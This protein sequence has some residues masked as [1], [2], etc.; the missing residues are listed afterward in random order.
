MEYA[1]LK[2]LMEKYHVSEEQLIDVLETQY[3]RIMCEQYNSKNFFA[4]LQN[5]RLCVYHF[6]ESPTSAVMVQ[7]PKNNSSITRSLQS[8]V[9]KELINLQHAND[10]QFFK[11]KIDQLFELKIKKRRDSEHLLVEVCNV[12][13]R[14]VG[15][16]KLSKEQADSQMKT[17][18]P[19][20]TRVFGI[21]SRINTFTNENGTMFVRDIV[22]ENHSEKFMEAF[23][24]KMIPYIEN[25]V[26]HIEK[27]ARIPGFRTK[28]VVSSPTST[29]NAAGMCIGKGGEIVN[30]LREYLASENIDFVNEGYDL[31]T[32]LRSYCRPFKVMHIEFLDANVVKV[33]IDT[34]DLGPLVHRKNLQLLKRLLFDEKS[35]GTSVGLSFL[36]YSEYQEECIQR[37]T[38]LRNTLIESGI[39]ENDAN[40]IISQHD[41]LNDLVFNYNLNVCDETKRIL[42]EQLEHRYRIMLQKFISAGGKK[43]FFDYIRTRCSLVQFLELESVGVIS[44]DKLLEF[45][46]AS[47]LTRKCNIDNSLATLLLMEV[48][49]KHELDT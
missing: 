9:H 47:D 44:F 46:N 10:Y 40:A 30:K 13:Y 39:S 29:N 16:L 38:Q 49:N 23:L 45:E 25:G 7:A 11:D 14:Y 35:C 28:V 20:G 5:G 37:T 3:S 33:V 32:K 36:T 48:K 27:I 2:G 41:D 1:S 42:A 4:K 31:A 24:H 6:N 26:I 22:F 34:E 43:E 8:A 15:D 12:P 18:Y 17:A 21:L 19:E